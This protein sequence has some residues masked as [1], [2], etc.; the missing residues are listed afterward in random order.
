[1]SHLFVF[2]LLLL[3]F[4]SSSTAAQGE[5]WC[6]EGRSRLDSV[7]FLACQQHH[8]ARLHRMGIWITRA[9]DPNWQVADISTDKNSMKNPANRSPVMGCQCAST[10]TCS[11]QAASL[12]TQTAQSAGRRSGQPGYGRQVS[13]LSFDN[14]ESTSLTGGG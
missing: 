2:F 8:L 11:A 3:P 4:S 10:W 1:M 6:S 14:W 9:L 13:L 5:P 12:S 7:A